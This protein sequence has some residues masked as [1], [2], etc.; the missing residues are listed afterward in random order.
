MLI[1]SYSKKF[2][3]NT[4]AKIRNSTSINALFNLSHAMDLADNI[5]MRKVILEYTSEALL[6]NKEKDIN[7]ILGSGG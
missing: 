3:L 4:I 5:D 1:Y 6:S 7:M 2:S